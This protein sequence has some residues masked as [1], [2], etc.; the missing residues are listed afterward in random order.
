[1]K[2]KSKMLLM[3]IGTMISVS[4][5][6]QRKTDIENSKDYPLI[7]RFEGAVIEFYKETKW[8]T[9][10]M[11]V[12]DNGK[13][14]FDKPK[15]LEGKVIRTQ[16]S[17]SIDDNPAYLLQNYK[18]AFTKAGF[19]ILTSAADEGLGVGERSQDWDSR[20]YGSGDAYFSNALNNG[21]FG[22]AI[23]IPAWKRNQAFIV[24]NIQKDGKDI[25]ISLYC[26]ENNTF[27]LINQDVIEVETA[28]V[29]DMIKV[30]ANEVKTD[31][32]RK[33]PTLKTA[34]E[35]VIDAQKTDAAQS[36]QS[37]LKSKDIRS[38]ELKIGIGAYS[39]SDPVLAGSAN[40]FMYNPTG[41][42]TGS[43]SGYRLLLSPYLNIRYFFN[44]NFGISL[45][46]NHM[47]NDQDIYTSDT[48]YNSSANL[49]AQKI[50]LTGQIV[51][52]STPVRLSST[53][54]AG[55]C[56]TELYQQIINIPS[57]GSDIYLH[58]KANMVV[59]FFNVD[60]SFP[61]YK[62]LFLFGDY[63]YN[64][65]PVGTFVMEHDGGNDYSDTYYGINFGGSH[66]RLGL[67]YS[68]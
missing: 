38:F 19:T 56:I 57:S 13:I 1:M 11:P 28:Q 50:G 36:D 5:F 49:F 64:L 43:A 8:G 10:K 67:G 14:N 42:V 12:D 41:V 44:E 55:N 30:N 29:G 21:K 47:S 20:Y 46:I 17:V 7:G 40:N 31:D 4:L 6:A 60:V 54:G 32:F 27:T 33:D 53:I 68:F 9:Y 59:L 16:Y 66:F 34:K 52:R 62:K 3:L 37:I 61:L 26:I 2:T 63:E 58:A 25:Y 23:G 18:A 48:H 45:D 51:G 24:A 65:I 35:D 22:G 15:I 39:F